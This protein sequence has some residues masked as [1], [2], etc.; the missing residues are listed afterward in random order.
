MAEESGEDWGASCSRYRLTEAS[1]PAITSSSKVSQAKT[2]HKRLFLPALSELESIKKKKKNPF[3][4]IGSKKGTRPKRFWVRAGSR[5][6]GEERVSLGRWV[7]R[8][9]LSGKHARQEDAQQKTFSGNENFR[10]AVA[11]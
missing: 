6:Q 2:Q 9:L 4:G 7:A 8:L 1:D 11:L 10:R 3:F 5:E